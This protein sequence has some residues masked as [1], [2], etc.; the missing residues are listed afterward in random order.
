MR[1]NTIIR[2]LF[3]VFSRCRPRVLTLAVLA[4]IGALLWLANLSGE[5]TPRSLDKIPGTAAEFEFDVPKSGKQREAYGF[6]MNMSYGWPLLWRQYVLMVYMGARV[7]GECH[8]TGRQLGNAALW[9]L[10]LAVPTGMCEWLLRRYRPR[11]RFSLRTLLVAT[12]LAAALFAWLAA[13]RNRANLQ[14][15]LIDAIESE[16][17]RI[18]VERRGPKWL[19]HIVDDRYRRRIVGVSLDV[20]AADEE[21]ERVG[22]RLV[23]DLKHLSDLRYFSLEASRLTPEITAAV[24]EMQRLEALEIVVFDFTADSSTAFGRA[25]RGMRRL[26]TLSVGPHALSLVDAEARRKFLAAIG[27]Q[28]RLEQLRLE[29]WE[30]DGQELALLRGLENLKSLALHDILTPGQS[31]GDPPLLSHLPPLPRL[32]ALDLLGS[33]I[34]DRDLRHVAALPRLRSLNLIGTNVTDA[35]LAELAQLESLEE[36]AMD[37][38][39]GQRG[40]FEALLALKRLK[41]LHIAFFDQRWLESAD[42]PD[43]E[44]SKRPNDIADWLRGLTAL[45]KANPG[46]AIDGDAEWRE[47]PE[48]ALAPRCETVG[49]EAMADSVREAARVWKE[50]Q[51]AK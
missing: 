6:E 5:L 32:E 21:E 47:P 38:D 39:A 22:Q 16:S 51:A 10:M 26:R 31:E 48:E 45:R 29:R 36:L 23:D 13:V 43:G 4:A 7:I 49:D 20:R 44:A 37:N 27:D 24:R 8:S 25:L 46:L 15:P 19:E 3:A 9:A 50:R 35:G 41:K 14:D 34:G 40:G 1:K 30:I 18:W 28:P 2:R 11:V 17:G 33:A 12:G 42:A